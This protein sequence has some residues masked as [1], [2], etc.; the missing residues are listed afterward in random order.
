MK[1]V[2]VFPESKDIALVDVAT[3]KVGRGDEVMIKVLEVGICGTDKEI[4]SFEYGSPPSHSDFLIIGHECLGEI[5]DVARE[6]RGLKVGDFAVITA[7][8]KEEIKND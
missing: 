4:C 2:G 6:V 5:I 7:G 3:P 8:R 1:A